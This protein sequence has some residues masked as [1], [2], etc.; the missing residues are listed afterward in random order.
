[1]IL[2]DTASRVLTVDTSQAQPWGADVAAVLNRHGQTVSLAG[3]SFGVT[4]TV[5]GAS[6]VHEWPAPGVVYIET[7]QDLLTSVRVSWA[8]DDAVTIA[9]WLESPLG[10]VEA[11]ETFIAPRPPRPYPSWTWQSGA[12]T[13]PVPYPADGGMYEW[14]EAGQEWTPV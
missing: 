12:W 8:P 9:A 5:N 10:R 3:V 4:V 1:M 2:Y 7:D 11:S 14:D 13:P 6:A